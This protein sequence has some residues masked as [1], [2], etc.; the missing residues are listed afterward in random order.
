MAP[1]KIE[2]SNPPGGRAVTG[3]PGLSIYGHKHRELAFS[4]LNNPFDQGC[5]KCV[6]YF[7]F[8]NHP[9]HHHGRPRL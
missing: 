1:G 7:A 4:L 9:G 3:H 5:I 2:I 6:I 8:S